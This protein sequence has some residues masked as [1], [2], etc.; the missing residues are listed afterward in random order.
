MKEK[1]QHISNRRFLKGIY[2]QF[3]KWIT[4]RDYL[5]QDLNFLADSLENYLLKFELKEDKSCHL[6]ASCFHDVLVNCDSINYDQ[7]GRATAY[8]ILHFLDRY[9]RFQL[10]SLELLKQGLLPVR[11][12]QTD[13]LEIGSG[14][15]P[16]MFAVAD[17]LL[18]LRKFGEENH[19]NR[20]TS[21]KFKFDYVESSKE[22][23]KWLH[24]F[25]EFNNYNMNKER[26]IP[27][28]HGTYWNFHNLDFQK[29]ELDLQQQLIDEIVEEDEDTTR[30]YAQL[31]VDS[32]ERGW[33]DTHRYNMVILSNF[34]TQPAQV[35]ELRRELISISHALRNGGIL[36]IVGAR[37]G[38]YPQIYKRISCIFKNEK[39][40]ELG[41]SASSSE[42]FTEYS[43]GD[44]FGQRIG[45][46]YKTIINRFVKCG[47]EKNIPEKILKKIQKRI[48]GLEGKRQ[49]NVRV[50]RKQVP[51]RRTLKLTATSPNTEQKTGVT[52]SQKKARPWHSLY[53][54]SNNWVKNNGR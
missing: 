16:A 1:T 35:D 15:A 12:L 18:L 30:D 6:I 2:P 13:I 33:K 47:A 14:P 25:L 17:M 44:L 43:H 32:Q 48:Y 5:L 50:F 34:L 39:Y 26:Q 4:T 9:H 27:Y 51:P 42:S 28:H 23:R 40:I 52:A 31:E 10:I 24:A 22:F 11:K 8:I 37:R 20:L 54:T 46:F 38:Q 45:R 53:F 29:L 19:I 21:I 49:W 36:V 41:L 3:N 7:P